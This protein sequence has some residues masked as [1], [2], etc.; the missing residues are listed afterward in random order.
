M[1]QSH[2]GM[3]VICFKNPLE[4]ILPGLLSSEKDDAIKTVCGT[5][6]KKLKL[7]LHLCPRSDPSGSGPFFKNLCETCQTS[8]FP[9]VLEELL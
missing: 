3:L 7:L 6:K 5:C 9:F 4:K 1:N 2:C 8:P